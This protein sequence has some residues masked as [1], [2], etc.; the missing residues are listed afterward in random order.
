[1]RLKLIACLLLT[2][3]GPSHSQQLVAHGKQAEQQQDWIAAATAY[4]SACQVKPSD[5]ATCARGDQMRDYAVD[6]YSFNAQKHCAAGRLGDCLATLKPIRSLKT[7]KASKISAVLSQAAQ[8]ASDRCSVK[9]DSVKAAVTEVQCLQGWRTEL[10]DS[11]AFRKHYAS[12]ATAT[13]DLLV[14]I[15]EGQLGTAAGARLGYLRAADCLS[16]LSPAAKNALSVAA[17]AFDA[18]SAIPLKLT[19]TV[20]GTSRPAPGTC[21][22]IASAIGGGL[23]CDSAGFNNNPGI[24]ATAEVYSVEPRWQRTHQDEQKSARYQSGTRTVENPDYQQARLEYEL[25]EQRF[26]EI[27]RTTNDSEQRCRRD[28][29]DYD[30]DRYNGLVDTYNQRKRELSRARQQAQAEPATQTEDVYQEHLY[31]TR[32]HRWSAAFRASIRLGTESTQP[33]IT[34]IVYSD[35]EQ[36][37]FAAAG[38][39]ADRFE[40]PSPTYFRDQSGKWLIKRIKSRVRGELATRSMQLREGCDDDLDCWITAERWSGNTQPGRWLL[41]G[42]AKNKSADHGLRCVSDSGQ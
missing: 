31:S 9:D 22:E 17:R 7:S 2:A 4:D 21:H 11:E 10:W 13:S 38:I 24:H 40:E 15:S 18:R 23:R 14:E 42:L 39:T 37:G 27:E 16:P 19:Y 41:N 30:C 35:I 33:E 8:L 12:Q 28:G 29:N 34:E 5:R 3:C 36:Q 6:L 20:K 26:A 25:A 1:M 32:T